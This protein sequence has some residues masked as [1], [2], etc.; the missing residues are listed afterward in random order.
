MYKKNTSMD[1]IV[2]ISADFQ[3]CMESVSYSENYWL[4]YAAAATVTMWD[5]I[6]S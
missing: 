5:I 3:Q 1:N 6:F 4:I 2:T